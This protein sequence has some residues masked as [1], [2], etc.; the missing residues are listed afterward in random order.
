MGIYDEVRRPT[1]LM[2]D[3]LTGVTPYEEADKSIQSAVSREFYLAACEVLNGDT[4]QEKRRRLDR[5]P[6]YVKKYVEDEVR[7][8]IKCRSQKLKTG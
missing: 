5:V 2:Q 4:P 6:D 1:L 3:V 7:R 8:L